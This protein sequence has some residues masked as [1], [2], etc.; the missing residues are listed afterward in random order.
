MAHCE[1]LKQ[2][3]KF[4]RLAVNSYGKISNGARFVTE[5]EQNQKKHAP[6]VNN[7]PQVLVH[8]LVT[9]NLCVECFLNSCLPIIINLE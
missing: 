8:K 2:K 9:Q 5:S 7:R 1:R 6:Y 4:Q 3:K